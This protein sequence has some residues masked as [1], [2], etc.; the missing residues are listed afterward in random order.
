MT[1]EQLKYFIA[2]VENGTYFNASESLHISQSNLSKQI[3]KLE[4]ELNIDL[5]DRRLR[6]ASLTD[7]GRLFYNDAIILIN[8]Y[9]IALNNIS[10]YKKFNDEKLH[11]GTLPIQTQ[12]NL[13]SIFNE[14]KKDNPEINLTIDE[15]EDEKLLE[16]IKMDEYHIIL[17]R[18][19]MLNPKYY[20]IYP[21][22]KDELV[23]V[24]PLGHK[25]SK[26][27]QL[28][29]NQLSG[30]N[31]ILMNPYTYIYQLCMNIIEEY[32]ISANVVRTARTESIIGA[33][34]L[35]EGISLLPKKNI[36]IFHHKNL[37]TVPLNH[38]IELSVIAAKKKTRA[39]TPALNKLIK[40][41]ENFSI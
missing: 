20:D 18:E 37:V 16:G 4:K 27:S 30:E 39:N 6:S 24:L 29:F 2:I 25:L 36:E 7:A 11:I 3:I 12:Y 13:T 17:A 40:F 41:I 35:N 33:V 38:N 9:N 31:F 23:V 22:A 14:F 28:N 15:V 26:Y 10:N 8:Q 34:A 19:N 1:F 5:F 32:N 21:I